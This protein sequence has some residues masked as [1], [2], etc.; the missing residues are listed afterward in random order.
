VLGGGDVVFKVD[1]RMRGV[2][3][4]TPSVSMGGGE[5]EGVFYSFK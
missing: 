4:E 2:A 1:G 3:V 5:C